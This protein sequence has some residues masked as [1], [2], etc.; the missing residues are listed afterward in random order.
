MR[1]RNTSQNKMAARSLALCEAGKVVERLLSYRCY[2]FALY[3]LQD[4]LCFLLMYERFCVLCC[5]KLDDKTSRINV[6]GQS[7]FPIE[8]E[9]R[10]SSEGDSPYERAPYSQWQSPKKGLFL[11]Q[12]WQEKSDETSAKVVKKVQI[13]PESN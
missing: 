1:T 6:R 9:L 12:L 10:K 3:M 5:R 7:S 2:W 8:T 4:L 11:R 13:S